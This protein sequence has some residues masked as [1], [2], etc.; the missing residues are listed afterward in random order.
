MTGPF[1][2][3]VAVVTGAARGLGREIATQL[4]GLGA[5]VVVNSRRRGAHGPATAVA[6]EIVRAGGQGVPHHGSAEDP[7]TAESL[8]R[9]AVETYGRLDVVVANAAVVGAEPFHRTTPAAIAEV[10][11]TNLTGPAML[12]SAA[13]RYLR[14]HGGGRILLL[15]STAGLHGAPTIASYAASKSAVHGLGLSLALEGVRRGV[16][17][18][19]LLPYA[20]T[21]DPEV[22]ASNGV[23][24]SMF[25][26]AAAAAVAVGLVH[27][28]S[29]IHG[30]LVV[31]GGGGV[32]AVDL[33]QGET[34]L[35]DT[36]RPVDPAELAARLDESLAGVRHRYADGATAM[37]AMGQEVA[38]LRSASAAG[39]QRPR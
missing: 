19:V 2:G 29:T 31:A 25:E 39:P 32:R 34:R 12:A 33:A 15:G 38:A 23:D 11:G 1:G 16:L 10:I 37:H 7:A 35:V 20:D 13:L 28:D 24:V 3:R 17:V 36:S 6:D 8:V 26:P 22:A 4:A 21:A 14:E 30:R 18:N 27:P 9:C 5:Q